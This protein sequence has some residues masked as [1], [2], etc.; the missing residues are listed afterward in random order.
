M[1]AVCWLARPQAIGMHELPFF[2]W[3]CAAVLACCAADSTAAERCELRPVANAGVLFRSGESAFLFDAPFRDGVA[4]YPAPD[5]EQRRKL[6]SAAPPYD[7]VSAILITHW[8]D[9]HFDADAVA[10]HLRRAP[11][12]KLVS[13]AEVVERVRRAGADAGRLLAL[14][15]AQGRSASVEIGGV[16]IHAVRLRHNPARRMPEQH[17]GFLVEGCRS[18][19]HA[20]DA[21]PD[22]PNFAAL[23]GLGRIDVGLLPYWYLDGPDNRD[24]VARAIAPGR[25]FAV[26]VPRAERAAVAQALR[27]VPKTALL[28]DEDR[29]LPL[30]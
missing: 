12:A 26:H 27:S 30:R 25:T 24:F 2:R 28:P 20:G 1:F 19:F 6:E 5:P 17:L 13:S 11:G 21:N 7:G 23:R 14:T 4:P 16:R 22:E 29:A 15:P 10:A 9:D 3:L 18:V 8:H